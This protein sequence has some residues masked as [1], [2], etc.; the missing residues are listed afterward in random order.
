MKW[1]EYQKIYQLTDIDMSVYKEVHY[2]AQQFSPLS[3]IYNHNSEK[4]KDKTNI[5]D[6]E[7]IRV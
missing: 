5:L 7:E 1:K 4:I 2:F 6:Y 3:E